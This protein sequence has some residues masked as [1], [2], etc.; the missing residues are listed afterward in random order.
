MTEFLDYIIDISNSVDSA[1]FTGNYNE[2]FKIVQD[3]EDQKATMKV[4]NILNRKVRTVTIIPSKKWE[5]SDSL[6]GALVRYE[7]Y[8]SAFERVLRVAKVHPNSPA[9]V[10]GL[11]QDSDYIL[12]S[13]QYLYTDLNELA[14]FIEMTQ[15][16]ETIKSLELYVF[17]SQTNSVR[18]TLIIPNK[19]WGGPG[20]LGCEFALGILNYLPLSEESVLISSLGEIWS[21]SSG[22][23][24][25]LDEDAQTPT[26]ATESSQLSTS[27]NNDS[28]QNG[29]DQGHKSEEIPE[30]KLRPPTAA[31][32]EKNKP[33]V[34][35][36]DARG[37][38]TQTYDLSQ[39]LT[40]QRMKLLHIAHQHKSAIKSATKPFIKSGRSA[41]NPFMD[42]KRGINSE[43]DLSSFDL[44]TS[45]QNGSPEK[46]QGNK[47]FEH[48][49]EATRSISQ[50]VKQNE[51]VIE[52]Y[53]EIS[54][55]IQ[56]IPEA[57]Q[58]I[59]QPENTSN[60]SNDPNEN[61]S[62]EKQAEISNNEPSNVQT[63]TETKIEEVKV[64]EL[65][66]V[67]ERVESQEKQVKTTIEYNFFSKKLNGD[68][69]I[70]S[71]NL[72]NIEDLMHLH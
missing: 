39:E 36:E 28:A 35:S 14:N 11:Q 17:S 6:L 69:K 45:A 50:E 9:S 42:V 7:E 4:Y 62:L 15:E 52:E 72:F 58:R 23:V 57:T 33:P 67:P 30:F 63:N 70:K 8:A 48:H 26:R 56:P 1:P 10:A 31:E 22:E 40:N 55:N 27:G 54:N 49:S 60:I 19:N 38:R 65:I 51:V 18:S 16:K 34:N 59:E 41:A 20:H 3:S 37:A 29:A 13:P 2:F 46:L 25:R 21:G 43:G 12:G 64:E 71:I 53:P 68:Y 24:D 47:S 61:S 32:I 5:N 66:R 44:N